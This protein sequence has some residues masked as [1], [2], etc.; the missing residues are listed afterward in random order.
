MELTELLGC[1]GHDEASHHGTRDC[2]P[3]CN[4]KER[5]DLACTNC[6]RNAEEK[7]AVNTHQYKEGNI[8]A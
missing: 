2:Y 8:M 6:K 5:W 4:G 1:F 7:G 3:P